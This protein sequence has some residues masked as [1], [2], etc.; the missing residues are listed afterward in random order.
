[1]IPGANIIIRKTSVASV[2]RAG[3]SGPLS[4]GFRGQTP[5]K[6]FLAS[7]EHLGWLKIDLN[8]V[9]IRTVQDFAPKVNM[10]I[11]AKSQAG[12]I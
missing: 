10:N 1:M 2:N 8:A 9:K 11:Q 3:C 4:R 6:I 5:L 7:K 12:N